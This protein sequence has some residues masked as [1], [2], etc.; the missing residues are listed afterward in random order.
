MSYQY[1]ATA[2]PKTD[3]HTVGL[4]AG[5]IKRCLDILFSAVLLVLLSPILLITAIVSAIDTKGSPFFCQWRGGVDGKPFCI[6]KF[7][8][9]STEAPANVAT[10]QLKNPDQY[11][12]RIGRLL[13][14]SSLDELP[15]LWNIL[16]GDMSFIGPRPVV[17]TEKRLL[18]L[19]HRNGADH[20]RP[21]L[22]GLAQISGRDDLPIYKKARLDAFYAHNMSLKGDLHILVKTV[23]CVLKADGVND[24]P[25][26]Q[27]KAAKHTADVKKRKSA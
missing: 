13:R 27:E 7:R 2:L 10:C 20:V 5:G 12:S 14:K 23:C 8:T 17:L 22:T 1:S 26:R 25:R 16:V 6:V 11:I 9:M 19:R 18:G 21:G 3:M 24:G 4:Y 15:Q